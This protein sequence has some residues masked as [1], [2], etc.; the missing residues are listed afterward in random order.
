[1]DLIVEAFGF[2]LGVLL[3]WEQELD[4]LVS[5]EELRQDKDVTGEKVGFPSPSSRTPS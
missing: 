2:S 4:S 3:E 1:M 5:H